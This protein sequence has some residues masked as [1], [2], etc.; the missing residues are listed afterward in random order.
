MFPR[1]HRFCS[2]RMSSLLRT[3]ELPQLA[4]LSPIILLANFATLVSTY[5]KGFVILIEPFGD[6]APTVFNPIMHFSCMDAS[7]AIKPVFARFQSVIITSGTLSPLDMYPRI[8]DFQPVTMATFTMTLAR[9]CLCP[10]V[11]T[12]GNDQVAISSKFETREDVAVIRNY[13]NLLVAM[14]KIVPDGVVCFFVSYVYMENIVSAWYEQ[15]ILESIQK[16]KLLFIE[17]QDAAETSMALD[18]YHE[19]CNNGR[20]AVLLSVARGKV[21]E[22][23]DFTHHLGRA[24]IMFGIPY[25]YTQSRI[26]RARL[27]YLRDNF[28]IRESDF[29]TFDALRHAAQC[30]GRVIRGKTDYG[31]MVFADK[32]FSRSDKRNKLPRWIQEHLGDNVTNL[33]TDEC[34]HIAKRFLRVMAQPFTKDDQLGLSLLTH[35]QLETKEMQQRIQQLA[36]Q[37]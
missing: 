36:H 4:D 25:V 7:I 9:Q 10:M 6:K 3:L 26:L 18:K 12:R 11:V 32:R 14:C 27:D 24:V 30:V 1:L 15:G 29:L 8:L 23:I 31:I 20:G 16:N 22:G 19:A 37:I 2:E 17:T 34:V 21:S 35:D 5:N 28:Q 33:S 13:G